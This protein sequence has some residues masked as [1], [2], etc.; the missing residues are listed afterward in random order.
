[1]AAAVEARKLSA[2]DSPRSRSDRLPSERDSGLVAEAGCALER[3]SQGRVREE[4]LAPLEARVPKLAL[5]LW[6][7]LVPAGTQQ[8]PEAAGLTQHPPVRFA[9]RPLAA[10]ADASPTID[11]IHPIAKRAIQRSRP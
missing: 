3:H 6:R 1:V 7:G 8:Q 5:G 9:P 2:T 10:H 4:R 11:S